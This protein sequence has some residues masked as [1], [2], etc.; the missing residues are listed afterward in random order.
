MGAV[1]GYSMNEVRRGLG[2]PPIESQRQWQMVE[3]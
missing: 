2:K 3:K 1:Y